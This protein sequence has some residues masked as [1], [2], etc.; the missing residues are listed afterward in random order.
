MSIPSKLLKME[1]LEKFAYF[2]VSFRDEISCL[3]SKSVGGHFVVDVLE[4]RENIGR[5]LLAYIRISEFLLKAF[6]KAKLNG[7]F[8]VL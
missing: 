7:T 4:L 5:I 6:Y 1:N 2:D 8:V 3:M